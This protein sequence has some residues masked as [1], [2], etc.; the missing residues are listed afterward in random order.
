MFTFTVLQGNPK[1]TM[2]RRLNGM[3]DEKVEKQLVNGDARRD[4][5]GR[6]SPDLK[7]TPSEIQK[8]LTNGV[9]IA[10]DTDVKVISSDVKTSRLKEKKVT[11]VACFAFLRFFV[12]FLILEIRYPHNFEILLREFVNI[13]SF[14][15]HAEGFGKV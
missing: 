4:I 14:K 9:V 8:I 11:V 15:M 5:N 7:A 12:L 1:S 6:Q 10:S 3:K 2:A 13:Y